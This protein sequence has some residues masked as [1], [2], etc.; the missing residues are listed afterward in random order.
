MKVFTSHNLEW[1]KFRFSVIG[2]LL[3]SPPVRGELAI[4]LRQLSSREFSHPVTGEPVRFSFSTLETW[5]YM[6]RNCKGNPI[7]ELS[8]QIRATNGTFPA[9]R[10]EVRQ[11]LVK[12]YR[13][14]PSW[15]YQLHLDNVKC[16]YKEQAP[17]YS[18]LMR[19]MKSQGMYPRRRIRAKDRDKQ[20]EAVAFQETREVRS[21]EAE[22]V[23]SLWHLDFHH[24]SRLII[25]ESGEMA[26]VYLLVI[27]DDCSRLVCHAQW[28]LSENSR[29]LVH[30]FSQAVL[31]RGKP[32]KLM[33]DGGS[34]MKSAEFHQGM[35]R[36]GVNHIYTL[37]YHP[38]QNGKQENFF[39]RVETRLMDMLEGVKDLTLTQLNQATNAWVE[40]EYNREFHS[41]IGKSPLKCFIDEKSVLRERPEVDE[42]KHSFRMDVSKK[43]RRSDGTVSI[44]NK[45]FEVPSHYKHCERI[46]VRYAR[47]DLSNVHMVDPK[48]GKMLARLY[49]LDKKTN[50]SG[51]RRIIDE[52]PVKIENSGEMAPLLKKYMQQYAQT[53]LPFGYIADVPE[54]E[55]QK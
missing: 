30:G 27:M 24:S 7:E 38:N 47:W 2:D 10:E 11:F 14:H 26:V 28:Y 29:C 34:A 45:R 8:D 49:P 22:F 55:E 32:Y 46:I 25:L 54:K 53:G 15:Q 4:R 33:S 41:E 18:T 39:A 1:G 3:A 21:F 42:L 20:L 40:M 43:Q 50:S 6:A 9:V 52:N 16:L 31:K 37:P 5:Y 12:Q 19:Y 35:E 36:I 13:E 44:E 17:S 48:S 23:G 51:L